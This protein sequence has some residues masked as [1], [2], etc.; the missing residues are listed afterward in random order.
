MDALSVF[1]SFSV[2][3]APAVMRKGARGVIG[4]AGTI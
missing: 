4:C 3:G 1:D 2:R